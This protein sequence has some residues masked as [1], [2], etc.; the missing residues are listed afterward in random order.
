MNTWQEI[1]TAVPDR[2]GWLWFAGWGVLSLV[3]AAILFVKLIV[4]EPFSALLVSRALLGIAMLL[5]PLSALQPG[6]Q[7]WIN[8]FL[9]MGGCLSSVLIATNWCN[10]PDKSVGPLRAIGRWVI[11]KFDAAYARSHKHEDAPL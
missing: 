10:R 8:A 1:L 11:A 4:N 5:I 6:W 2:M 3:G 7:P 9:A